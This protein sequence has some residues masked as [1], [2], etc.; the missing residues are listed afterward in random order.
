MLL[1]GLL[2]SLSSGREAKIQHSLVLLF[3]FYM[4]CHPGTL[5]YSHKALLTQ[6]F[7]SH[8]V[9]E[10]SSCN[11]TNHQATKLRR[12]LDGCDSPLASHYLR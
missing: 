8:T 7:V 4:G 2:A 9:A 5:G 6:G 1:A 11:D 3:V 12:R 10:Q